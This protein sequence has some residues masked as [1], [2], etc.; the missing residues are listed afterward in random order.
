MVY[1]GATWVL[2]PVAASFIHLRIMIQVKMEQNS[3]P[4]YFDNHFPI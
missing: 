1:M 2:Y 3:K 4:M